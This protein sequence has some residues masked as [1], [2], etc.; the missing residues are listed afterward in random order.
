V[1]K[2]TLFCGGGAVERKLKYYNSVVDGNGCIYSCDMLRLKFH[3]GNHIAQTFL[4]YIN[5]LEFAFNFRMEYHKSRTLKIGSYRHL[6][7]CKYDD[8]TFV[9]G[10][11]L[12]LA[13]NTNGMDCFI[14]FNPNK[15][16]MSYMMMILDRISVFLHPINN[17]YF[18]LIRWDLAVDLPFP[19][20]DVVLVKEGKRAYCKQISNS[21]TEYLGARNTSGFV[22]LYDKTVES[23]LY[24]DLTR[25]EITFDSFD[26]LKLPSVCVLGEYDDDLFELNSTDK[27]LLRLLRTVDYET[28]Q[29]Y[30]KEL[31]RVKRQKLKDY[32]FPRETKLVYNYFCID[33]VIL[34]IK[35]ILCVERDNHLRFGI[36]GDIEKKVREGVPDDEIFEQYSLFG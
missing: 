27:V 5:R 8:F 22:K 2:S 7:T 26:N 16:E 28:Q 21:V 30:L 6:F 18:R 9:I 14:E 15:C 36:L 32:L 13:D 1:S 12:I 20:S 31:G 35:E 23:D 3:I 34:G 29:Q 4:N 24:Y 19:R 10:C 25:L 17:E 11:G 33:I